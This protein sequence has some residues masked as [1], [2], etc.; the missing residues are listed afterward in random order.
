MARIQHTPGPWSV[1]RHGMIARN[2]M[3]I[4]RIYRSAPNSDGGPVVDLPYEQNAALIV[5]APETLEALGS[6]AS[7]LEGAAE[8]HRNSGNQ[9]MYEY[10]AGKAYEARQAIK[11]ARGL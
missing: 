3:P 8:A 6:A 11:K 5:A 9:T 2:Q 1:D 7:A 10:Y 4:A